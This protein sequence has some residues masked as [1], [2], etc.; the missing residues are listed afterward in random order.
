[1]ELKTVEKIF[2]DGL[3]SKIHSIWL[4]VIIY[5]KYSRL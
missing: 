5:T 1:M 3:A 2:G 4:Q